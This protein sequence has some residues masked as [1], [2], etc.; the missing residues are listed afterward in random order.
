M[1]FLVEYEII[2]KLGFLRQFSYFIYSGK[3]AQ[4]QHLVINHGED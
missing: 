3:P 2:I 4:D 1:V